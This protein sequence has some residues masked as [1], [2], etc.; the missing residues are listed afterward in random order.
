MQDDSTCTAHNIIDTLSALVYI[1]TSVQ[2]TPVH[3]CVM[4]A[5]CMQS[6]LHGE[7]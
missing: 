4:F 6:L 1:S 7:L 3:C 2:S 5:V